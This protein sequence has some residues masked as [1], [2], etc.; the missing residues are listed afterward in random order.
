M[1]F[2]Q[3][4]TRVCDLEVEIGKKKYIGSLTIKM[5]GKMSGFSMWDNAVQGSYSEVC[6]LKC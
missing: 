4:A 5:L 6:H 1:T 3:E 2:H